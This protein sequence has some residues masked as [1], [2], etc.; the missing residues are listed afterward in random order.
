MGN[1]VVKVQGRDI[2][3]SLIQ[4]ESG[5]I[6][7][8][9]AV[10]H[11]MDSLSYAPKEIGG[12]AWITP[13]QSAWHK[14][15]CRELEEELKNR[16]P[17]PE[18]CFFHIPFPEYVDVWNQGHCVGQK[19]EE[20]CCPKKNSGFF[21]ALREA[22]HVIGVFVGHDHIND[23][24]GELGGIRLCYGRGGSHHAYGKEGFLKGARVIRLQEGGRGFET[25]IRLEDGSV[26]Q[27]GG[28]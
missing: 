11:F 6:I 1:Y 28:N 2:P 24:V 23:Y 5:G 15:V 22:G 18:L 25:W 3:Q 4:K 21:A 17:V 26:E 12:Y 13:E 7:P 20:V 10:L 14:N 9:S 27:R 8:T 16:S 19:L